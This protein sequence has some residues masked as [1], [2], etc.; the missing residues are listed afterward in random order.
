MLK[1]GPAKQFAKPPSS[2]NE[3]QRLRIYVT[4]R[5]CDGKKSEIF[6]RET[7]ENSLMSAR[8]LRSRPDPEEALNLSTRDKSTD[9]RRERKNFFHLRKAISEPIK[10]RFQSPTGNSLK[11]FALAMAEELSI[12]QVL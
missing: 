10:T 12:A 4:K 7:C 5:L 11:D 1:A 3:T 9:E 2:V 8:M 6:R